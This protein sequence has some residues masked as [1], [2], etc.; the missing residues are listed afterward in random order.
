[1]IGISERLGHTLS[2]LREQIRMALGDM[3][4]SLL[5]EL[6][7]TLQIRTG[8]TCHTYSFVSALNPL[9]I[10]SFGR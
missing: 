8:K 6:N 5:C 7:L 4:F 3:A 10:A 2:V 1:L 9:A